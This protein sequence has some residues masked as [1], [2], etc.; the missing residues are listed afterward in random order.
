MNDEEL[1]TI[2]ARLHGLPH[3]ALSTELRLLLNDVRRYR[4]LLKRVE[5]V[6]GL[7]PFCSA[8]PAYPSRAYIHRGDCLAFTVEGAVR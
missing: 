6:G 4:G 7:C 2:E 5:L 1:A 8:R 3:N